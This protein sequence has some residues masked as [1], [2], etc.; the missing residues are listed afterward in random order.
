MN[1]RLPSKPIQSHP[2][3]PTKASQEPI[4]PG[5]VLQDRNNQILQ[6]QGAIVGNTAIARK[7]HP[8]IMMGKRAAQMTKI[9]AVIAA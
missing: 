3:A 5:K 1:F 7:W 9:P 8:Q 4:L 6:I 2:Q